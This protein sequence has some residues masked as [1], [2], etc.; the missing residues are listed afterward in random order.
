MASQ[1]GSGRLSVKNSTDKES[2]LGKGA[3]SINSENAGKERSKAENSLKKNGRKLNSAFTKEEI[4]QFEKESLTI[5]FPFVKLKGASENSADLS[6]D[7]E[8]SVRTEVKEHSENE[9]GREKA[10][11]LK[12]ESSEKGLIEPVASVNERRQT[13]KLT[14]NQ[15]II[16]TLLKETPKKGKI[17]SIA[18][19]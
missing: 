3:A 11:E 4:A 8:K 1:V 12:Q 2:S 14:K 15:Q 5:V 13:E 17:Q 10:S 6:N 9:N 18:L 7:P 19:K 16:K